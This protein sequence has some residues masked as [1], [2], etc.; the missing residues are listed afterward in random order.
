LNN[1]ESLKRF[2][3]EYNAA[4][5]YKRN[6][7]IAYNKYVKFHGLSWKMPLYAVAEKRP[8]IPSS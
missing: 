4:N 3:G 1:A 5:G 7:A 6:L 8:K 2:I